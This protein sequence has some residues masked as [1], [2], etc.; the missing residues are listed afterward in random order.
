MIGYVIGWIGAAVGGFCLGALLMD[1]NR[2]R[3]RAELLAVQ[4]DR[5]SLDL[6]ERRRAL[7]EQA[8]LRGAFLETLSPE[9]RLEAH[10]LIS[11]GWKALAKPERER[12]YREPPQLVSRQ[13]QQA[14]ARR[15]GFRP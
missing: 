3:L 4:L 13:R 2:R 6:D 14:E 15:W 8:S 7:A 10:R 1:S 11:L 5:Q 9:Q 12:P